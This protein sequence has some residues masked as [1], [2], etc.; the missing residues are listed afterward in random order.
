VASE[1][2]NKCSICIFLSPLN[3]ATA[4]E[5]FNA[6]FTVYE[7]IYSCCVS[8]SS[9]RLEAFTFGPEIIEYGRRGLSG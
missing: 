9:G 3:V 8:R 6:S 4:D 7:H 2:V 1:Q 5:G